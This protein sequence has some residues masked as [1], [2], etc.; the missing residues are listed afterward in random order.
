MESSN[1]YPIVPRR[2]SCCTS[3]S[4]IRSVDRAPRRLRRADLPFRLTVSLDVAIRPRMEKSVFLEVGAG[5]V[6]DVTIRGRFV[7]PA[8]AV[9]QIGRTE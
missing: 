3:R 1:R 6:A 8:D 7:D 2:S 4:P 9:P 5:T